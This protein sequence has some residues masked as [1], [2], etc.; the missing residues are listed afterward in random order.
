MNYAIFTPDEAILVEQI[1]LFK[2]KIK[3]LNT[4]KI[5]SISIKKTNFIYS[6]FDD[7]VLTILNEGSSSNQRGEIVFKYVHNPE[8]L[9]EKI[10][11]ILYHSKDLPI[12]Q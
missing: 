6:L 5:K 11:S 1:G 3:T 2:R 8:L 10:Y 4:N 12:E 7:G 9:K